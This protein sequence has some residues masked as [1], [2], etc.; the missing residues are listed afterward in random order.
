M[1]GVTAMMEDQINGLVEFRDTGMSKLRILNYKG[2]SVTSL[3]P[4]GYY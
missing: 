2:Q 4:K 3:D 1:D